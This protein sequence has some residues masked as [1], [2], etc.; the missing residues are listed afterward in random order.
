MTSALQDAQA[1][2]RYCESAPK[3]RRWYVS[4]V[5]RELEVIS[6]GRQTTNAEGPEGIVGVDAC[7]APAT[8]Q[9]RREESFSA[10]FDRSGKVSDAPGLREA[11]R[12]FGYASSES[13]EEGRQRLEQMDW[14]EDEDFDH[15][16][17]LSE[18]EFR[19]AFHY[20]DD[21]ALEEGM[22]F[23]EIPSENGPLFVPFSYQ[24]REASADLS[25]RLLH[26][27]LEDPR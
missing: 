27:E 13:R 21:S 15:P 9:F 26:E 17:H 24:A 23:V 12:A 18:K 3:V 10:Y 25:R 1:L 6:S 19:D 20:G 16:A 5:V 22:V 7:N 8:E 4:R 2:I 14:W 11:L